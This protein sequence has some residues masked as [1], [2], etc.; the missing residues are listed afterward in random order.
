MVH[1]HS[2]APGR[3]VHVTDSNDN[4][5]GGYLE[6]A[7]SLVVVAAGHHQG[8]GNN[9][10]ANVNGIE[11]D[12]YMAKVPGGGMTNKKALQVRLNSVALALPARSIRL[13]KPSC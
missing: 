2:V 12:S 9:G 13:L 5:T 1:T 6:V 11:A 3:V 4:L 8:G 7:N 10:A